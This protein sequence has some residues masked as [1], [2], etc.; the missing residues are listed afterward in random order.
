MLYFDFSRALHV[1]RKHRVWLKLEHFGISGSLLSWIDSFFIGTTFSEK[2][3]DSYSSRSVAIGVPQGSVLGPILFL[4][5]TADLFFSLKS[6]HAFYADASKIFGNPLDHPRLMQD[7]WIQ[8][9][10]GAPTGFFPL[11]SISVLYSIIT[12]SILASCILIA[13]EQPMWWMPRVTLALS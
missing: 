13:A 8:F 5:N 12:H 4:V 3:V 9:L 11:I 6:D 2:V 7:I 1:V 10:H